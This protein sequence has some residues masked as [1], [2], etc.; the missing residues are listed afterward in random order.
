MSRQSDIEKKTEELLAPIAQQHGVR[1]YDVEFVKEG[2]ERYLRCF[3][4]K[5]G[6]VTIDDCTDVS[7][8]L[9][10][11]L[12][13]DDFIGEGYILEVSSP[14]LGRSLTR[15]RHFQNSIGQEVEGTTFKPYDGTKTKVFEGILKAFDG[16]TVTITQKSA[17][18]ALSQDLVLPRKEIA[19]IRLKVDWKD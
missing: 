9:S 15:D 5:D 13:R 16:E 8:D 3:I 19:K 14:G 6:G 10:D 2:T 7:H 1:I 4:D 18:G 17:D 12:D 11:A